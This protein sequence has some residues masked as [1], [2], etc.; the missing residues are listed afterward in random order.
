MKSELG[1]CWLPEHTVTESLAEGSLVKLSVKGSSFRRLTSYLVVPSP[2]NAGPGTQLLE[3]LF[4]ENR[5]S[6]DSEAQY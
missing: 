6:F 1:F 4:I 3:S 2:D 5:Q